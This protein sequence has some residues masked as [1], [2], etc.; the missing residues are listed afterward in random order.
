MPGMHFTDTIIPLVTTAFWVWMLVDCLTSKRLR[1]GGK[2]GWG[3]FIFFTQ[4]V[5]ALIYFFV[6]CRNRNPIEAASYYYRSIKK[7]L[8]SSSYVPPMQSAPPYAPRYEPPP[9]TYTPSQS[10]TYEEGYAAA[11]Y[12]SAQQHAQSAITPDQLAQP[13]AVNEQAEYEEPM[14]TY[15]EMPG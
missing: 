15:P 14:I 1:T 7:S 2:I 8:G 6:E 13:Q 11:Q 3:L 9:S 5:G 10:H 4:I 12:Q